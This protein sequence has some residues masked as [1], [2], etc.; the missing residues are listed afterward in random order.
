MQ[1]LFKR[2]TKFFRRL[3]LKRRS[4]KIGIYGPPNSG[5]TTLAN[6]I[7]SDWLGENL[8]KASPIPH[9]TRSVQMK[10]KVT[11]KSGKNQLTFAL[12]DTPGIATRI[13][14][15]DFVSSGMSEK[16]AKQRAKEA[17]RG[18]IESIKWLDEMDIV[19]LVLDSTKDPYNQV[20]L[21]ILG[22][23]EAR[24]IPVLIVANKMDLKRA[25]LEKVKAAFP[26]HRV[27]SVSAKF[28]NNMDEFYKEL[29]E[30]SF[31]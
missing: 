29:V 2:F 18:V 15:E 28:G 23:L 10:E 24:N 20:N 8:G 5:K 7:W 14:Y 22:N 13:D 27:V 12:V 25:R 11:I 9:E 21:T 30:L 17:A 26:N 31:I 16:E 19:V 1:G 4:L 3:F 6:R